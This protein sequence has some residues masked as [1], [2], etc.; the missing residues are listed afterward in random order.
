MRALWQCPHCGNTNK[1]IFTEDEAFSRPRVE[2]CDSEEGGCDEYVAV[3]PQFT[4]SAE[5]FKITPC[6]EVKP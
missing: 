3:L 5:V 6:K 4:T 1:I 2:C